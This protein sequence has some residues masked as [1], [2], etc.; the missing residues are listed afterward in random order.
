MARFAQVIMGPAGSGKST[1]CSELQRYA[2]DSRRTIHIINLDP[3]AESFSYPVAADIRELIGV[4]EVAEEL[5][6]GPNG[7]LVYCMEYLLEHGDWL[8]EVINDF[9]EGE[10]VVFDLPGQIE[11][12]THFGFMRELVRRLGSWDFRVCAVYLMDSQFM[13]DG[14]K[15]FG[16]ALSALAAMVQ[17]E[18]PHVNIMSKMDL[19]DEGVKGRL[20]E[21][22]YPDT[23]ALVGELTERMGERYLKLNQAIANLLDDYGLVQFLPLDNLDNS[24]IGNIL[25]QIDMAL[26]F[27]ESQDI[28]HRSDDEG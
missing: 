9:G 11:L 23:G 28:S 3:A 4:S 26:Q 22:L 16:G 18:V 17:L 19:A 12:Y 14:A 24:S 7:A 13:A 21:F 27:E 6:L 5:E 10:Y 1:Y 25:L 15:F 2:S 20:D 8:E